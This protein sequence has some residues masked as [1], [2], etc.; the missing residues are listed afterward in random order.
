[1]DLFGP[2]RMMWGSD[3]TQSPGTYEHMVSLGRQAVESLSAADQEQILAGT[4]QRV[5]GKGWN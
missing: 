2:S 1:M 3:V 5:Y 4:A